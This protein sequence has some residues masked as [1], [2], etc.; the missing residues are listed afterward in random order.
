M[1]HTTRFVYIQRDC[2]SIRV[3]IFDLITGDEKTASVRKVAITKEL[4]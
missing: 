1:F 2:A 3:D 4:G